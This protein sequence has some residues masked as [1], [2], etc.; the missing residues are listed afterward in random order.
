VDIVTASISDQ[1]DHVRDTARP[2]FPTIM[3]CQIPTTERTVIRPAVLVA[4]KCDPT[5]SLL[6]I[7]RHRGTIPP[8]DANHTL[9]RANMKRPP[10]QGLS[11]RRSR[12]HVREW[13]QLWWRVEQISTPLGRRSA[14]CIKYKIHK[15]ADLCSGVMPRGII[16]IEGKRLI[17][18]IREQL[19][20]AAVL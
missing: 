20:E 10:D 9:G 1:T 19:D 6:S 2:A 14:R 17:G 13:A 11:R 15:C 12:T 3:P 7:L 18:P 5:E 16:G 4:D 8:E